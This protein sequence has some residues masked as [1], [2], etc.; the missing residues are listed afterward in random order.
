MTEREKLIEDALLIAS[1][2][3]RSKIEADQEEEE[4]RR[5]RDFDVA[6]KHQQ[7]RNLLDAAQSFAMVVL[8]IMS[9]ARDSLRTSEVRIVGMVPLA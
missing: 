7:T 5:L 4:Q 6:R 8:A 3:L 1:P 2:E 9:W